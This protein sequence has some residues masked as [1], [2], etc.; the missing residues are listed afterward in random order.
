MRHGVP[1]LSFQGHRPLGLHVDD[2][3]LEGPSLLLALSRERDR[4]LVLL[5]LAGGVRVH[6]YAIHHL[7]PARRYVDAGLVGAVL[8]RVPSGCDVVR[9]L[10]RRVDLDALDGSFLQLE[11]ARHWHVPFL[12]RDELAKP[13]PFIL[14][15]HE[16]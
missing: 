12:L 15:W 16:P 5:L 2:V 10:P 7:I 13:R 11:L 1:V 14:E 9:L 3:L 4:I 8:G 6:R